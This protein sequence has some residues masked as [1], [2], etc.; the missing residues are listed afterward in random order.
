[1][2]RGLS[3]SIFEA[4]RSMALCC[5]SPKPCT[6]YPR[7]Q[8]SSSNPCVSVPYETVKGAQ[9]LLRAL[10]ALVPPPTGQAHSLSLPSTSGLAVTIV[11]VSRTD[12]LVIEEA[13]LACD[14]TIVIQKILTLL[15]AP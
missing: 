6:C 12:T 14:V 2:T 15:P 13:D 4:A 8:P 1:M 11:R 10:T 9:S 5:K 7:C 3:G